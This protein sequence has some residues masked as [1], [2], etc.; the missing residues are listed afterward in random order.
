MPTTSFVKAGSQVNAASAAQALVGTYGM[1][2]NL[3]ITSG[4]KHVW[5]GPV[6]VHG[7]ELL[8]GHEDDRL[9]VTL[10]YARPLRSAELARL[11]LT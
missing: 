4:P 10:R 9:L 6:R 11:G 8:T 7:V 2:L 3:K 1:E 5:T